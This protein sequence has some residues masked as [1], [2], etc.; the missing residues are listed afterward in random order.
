MNKLTIV[1]K[2][3]QT[4]FIKRLSEE[5]GEEKIQ[6]FNPW[7]DPVPASYVKI[8]FR[9]SGIYHSDVDLDFVRGSGSDVMN[10]IKS[11]E[12][13]RSKSSQYE[14]F[15]QHSHP[16]LPWWR[17]KDW[18][19]HD[20]ESDE[21]LVKPD[22]GQGGWGIEVFS[23]CDLDRWKELQ[24]LKG[25]LSWVV[26]P[27]IKAQEYRVFFMGSERICL[28]RLP[29]KGE[30]VS[31]F[32]QEGEAKLVVLPQEIKEVI[33]PLIESSG[34]YYGAI[35]LLDTANGPAILELN[36]TPGI[37]QVEALAHQNLILALLSANFFC[38][39][40]KV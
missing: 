28:K 22:N 13:F 16:A 12:I 25:D 3:P 17:L 21:F 36:V 1:A 18:T 37:E 5:L 26:Q 35:D 34:A 6:H 40:I 31:N 8:L 29:K 27:Y 23:G 11:L 14:F 10:P 19:A 4:Y 33:G 20:K 32:A 38:H 2:N 39:I 24:R 7:I 9:S 30:L 15:Q